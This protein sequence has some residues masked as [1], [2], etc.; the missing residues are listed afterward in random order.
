MGLHDITAH[1]APL[2]GVQLLGIDSRPG[3]AE[4]SILDRYIRGND[5]VARYAQTEQRPVSPEVYWRAFT[6]ANISGI[7]LIVSMQT[8]RLE[9]DPSISIGNLLPAGQFVKGAVGEAGALFRPEHSDVSLLLAAHP[10]DCELLQTDAAPEGKS[11]ISFVLFRP[12]LEKGVIRRGRLRA[13]FLPRANDQTLAGEQYHEFL[14]S[15][16]PLTT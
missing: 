12:G 14:T 3:V 4:E 7:D 1:D 16:L 11:T 6:E 15:Q 10:S 2:S 13:A 8:D 5:L 9:S